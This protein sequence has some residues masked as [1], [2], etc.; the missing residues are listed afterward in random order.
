T[1]ATVLIL[2]IAAALF[3]Q[4]YREWRAA[5]DKRQR[6]VVLNV[7]YGNRA[8]DSGDLLRALPYFAEALRLDQR[9]RDAEAT[10]RLRLGSVLAQ[11]PKLTQMWFAST[12]VDD[13][14]FS[15]DSKSI[16]L[17]EN[18]GKAEIHDL[19]TGRVH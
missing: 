12:Q 3:Y 15:P 10:H 7:T 5:A 11:C 1:T 17:A 19:L 18:Y 16:V 6:E 8:M 9:N 14:E 4:G 2:A 13:G